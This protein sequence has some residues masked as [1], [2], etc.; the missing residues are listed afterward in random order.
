MQQTILDQIAEANFF[1]G[2]VAEPEFNDFEG[3]V[4]IVY[5]LARLVGGLIFNGDEF[6]EP[7]LA[8]Q[9]AP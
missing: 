6:I 9:Q 1:I 3:H 2:I 8:A 4:S 7:T 5:G